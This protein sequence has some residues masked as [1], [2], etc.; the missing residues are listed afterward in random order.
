[1]CY[2][3]NVTH[4]TYIKK[5]KCVTY[6]INVTY[7][8]YVTYIKKVTFVT[9]ITNVTYV[10]YITKGTCVTYII[11]VTYIMKMKWMRIGTDLQPYMQWQPYLQWRRTTTNGKDEEVAI[12]LRTMQ[13]ITWT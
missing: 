6:I 10:T 11:N 1:M 4:V 8:T 9:Y 2:I 3:I 7:V 13:M 12:P 5:V